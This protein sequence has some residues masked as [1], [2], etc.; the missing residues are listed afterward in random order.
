MKRKRIVLV[1]ATAAALVIAT[2]WAWQFM[3]ASQEAARSA[4]GDLAEG[5]ALLAQI[6]QFSRQP[7][8]AADREK[9]ETETHGL[10]E[11]AARSAGIPQDCL[12]RIS[13]MPLRRLGDT[14]YKERPTQVLLKSVTL[15][16]L[17]EMAS[18]PTLQQAA[19]N[20]EAIRLTAGQD[21]NTSDRWSAELDLTY[22][23][24]DPPQAGK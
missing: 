5:V 2:L 13:G 7:M 8:L 1:A 23:V 17:V 4:A 9:M 22:L 3:L 21:A 6:E 12:L 16:Q 24:Y 10:I 15:G 14:A 11:A 20:V 18:S 19:L